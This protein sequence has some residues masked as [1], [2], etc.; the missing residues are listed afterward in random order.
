MDFLKNAKKIPALDWNITFFGSHEQAVD[1]NW[2]VP[3]EKHYAFECIYVLEG[4]ELA[5]VYDN[6]YTLQTGDFLLVPPEFSHQ[7]WSDHNLKYFCFHF[8]IDDPA[9]KVQL[10]KGLNFHYPNDS[11]LTLSLKPHLLKLDSLASL[12]SFDFDTKM[13]I[14]IELSKILQ[15]FYQATKTAQKNNATTSAEYARIM[16]DFLKEA[17]TNQVLSYVKNGYLPENDLIEVS[18]AIQKVGISAGYGFRIFKETFGISP[19]EYLSKLKINEAKKLLSKPQ[20]SINDIGEALGYKSVAN[21][22]RQFK[23]WTAISP[24]QFRK[25]G[26]SPKW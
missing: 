14:Q 1:D 19:R 6:T 7:V 26:N 8:D 24:S 3:F 21:F 2:I 20:Y 17:L 10:I 25:S 5:K 22:S 4:Q 15:I 18:S 13:I 16:A 12:S 23:R 11:Q 9:L